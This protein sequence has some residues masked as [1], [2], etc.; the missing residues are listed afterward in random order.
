MIVIFNCNLRYYTIS[1]INVC[2]KMAAKAHRSK[3]HVRMWNFS[4][5]DSINE[6][7]VNNDGSGNCKGSSSSDK[8]SDLF[9]SALMESNSAPAS[10]NR[11]STSYKRH[12][13]QP[14]NLT[15][16]DSQTK[17]R[18]QTCIDESMSSVSSAGRQC[19][20]G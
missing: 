13:Y 18:I 16:H 15:A 14:R 19:Y 3:F 11:T 9:D 4:T 2:G 7:D 20:I 8:S 17:D 5:S 1:G 12:F 10:L 6:T